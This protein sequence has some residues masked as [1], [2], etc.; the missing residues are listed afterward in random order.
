MAMDLDRR[1]LE[2]FHV[3]ADTVL[4]S[5]PGNHPAWTAPLT[6]DE[7]GQRLP[8]L[9]ALLPHDQVR[10]DLRRFLALLRSAFGGM[11]LYRRPQ[12]FVSLPAQE[13][14][15]AYRKMESSP[16]SLVRG[17][18][19]ALKTL[20]AYLWVTSEGGATPSAWEAMG[21]PGPAGPPPAEPRRLPLTRI[22][23]DATLTADV[24]VVG[25]GAGGGTAAGVLAQAGL[26][27]VVLEAG[28][29]RDR[30]DFTH[31][32][33]DAYRDMYL[34]GG[35]AATADNGINLLAG[36]TL[37][38][39]TVINYT[40]SFPTPGP[41]RE[42]W[43]RVA[44]FSGVF[45]GDQFSHSTDAVYA[46]LG[47]NLE[48]GWPSSREQLL[49]KGLRQL[50]W[51]VHQMPR[52]AVGCLPEACGYCTMGCR[53]DAKRSMLLTYLAEAAGA[54][55]RLITEAHVMGV[56]VEGPHDLSV[57]AKVGG[58]DL[59][60]RARA[61]VLAA[62][63]LNT[64]ALLLRSHLGGP[65]TGR[66]LRLHPVTAVWGRF[67]EKVEPWTGIMQARFSDE[68]VDLD[69]EGYGFKFE[70]A[71]VHPL[72]PAAFLGWEDGLSYKWDVLSL[73]HTGLAGILLRD[74]G[75]GRVSIRGDGLPRWV[76]PLSPEDQRHLREGVRR[77][78][79]LLAAA[80]AVEVLSSTVRPVR[81]RPG[82]SSGLEDFVA[83][84]DRVGYGANRMSYFSFHQMGTARMG[85]DPE[86]SVVD[87]DN[88]VH[89]TSG[90][91]VLDGSCFPTASG[92]NPMI[93][94]AAIA[95]RGAT[96]LAER[97][98]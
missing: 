23:G 41:V 15:A 19:R 45:G 37:G 85:V 64:P 16:V 10:A 5:L 61:V 21:Y 88:Q 46:R 68:F 65:A 9:F 98:S 38:G 11:L 50:G 2:T 73:A 63:A 49:E 90:L 84:V 72:F 32:E 81:W 34:H 95:H 96:R 28:H 4:P 13:R 43:D 39:G 75:Q 30:S 62:G 3:V 24:V 76:Y 58:G 66:Y 54:G 18:A 79:E 60:V 1:D 80:G 31:R 40:T 55:A 47:V 53:L 52:N 8:V 59:R 78:A 17:G 70:T 77:G 92:V 48:H 69:G 93:S 35:L 94:I 29:Y 42:E 6:V 12:A 57:S 87:A 27:V 25:S 44:G 56:T 97:M 83:G 36:A 14:A 20:A 91:Y 7:L 82:R 67:S 74:R 26:S 71:P 33:A 22:E 89:G 51:H 86:T